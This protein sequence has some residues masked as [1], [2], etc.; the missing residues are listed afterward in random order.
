MLRL[1]LILSTLVLFSCG[2]QSSTKREETKSNSPSRVDELITEARL[3]SEIEKADRI[4]LS[5]ESD[6]GKVIESELKTKSS[7]GSYH[8]KL[9]ATES[10]QMLQDKVYRCALSK[11]YFYSPMNSDNNS[12]YIF[13]EK[14]QD[15]ITQNTFKT[16]KGEEASALNEDDCS[17]TQAVVSKGPK[18]FASLNS[19]MM[20]LFNSLE[21][22]CFEGESKSKCVLYKTGSNLYFKK[23]NE[24]LNEDDSLS[25]EKIILKI[26]KSDPSIYQRYEMNQLYINNRLVESKLVLQNSAQVKTRE[27]GKDDTLEL[28]PY[29]YFGYFEFNQIP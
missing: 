7:K 8:F 2:K 10:N 27:I 22:L 11:D 21:D 5:K 13:V 15:E 28:L 25:Y 4:K 16:E 29:Q 19:T 1:V 20:T 24:K 12:N 6:F 26:K 3:E 23:E 9:S 18:K 17:L 14:N